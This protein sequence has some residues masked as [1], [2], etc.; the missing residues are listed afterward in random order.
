MPRYAKFYKLSKPGAPNSY[1]FGG[2]N[3]PLT[4][5]SRTLRPN[6]SEGFANADRY[7]IESSAWHFHDLEMQELEHGKNHNPDLR[8]VLGAPLFAKVEK[9]IR[10]IHWPP[11]P[12]LIK[13]HF[14]SLFNPGI[15]LYKQSAKLLLELVI[16]HQIIQKSPSVKDSIKQSVLELK[17]YNANCF[18]YQKIREGASSDEVE[19]AAIYRKKPLITLDEPTFPALALPVM[20]AETQQKLI[21]QFKAALDLSHDDATSV[22]TEVFYPLY[23]MFNYQIGVYRNFQEGQP[24]H[25][26]ALTSPQLLAKYGPI[27]YQHFFGRSLAWME[28]LRG[29]LHKESCYINVHYGQLNGAGNLMRLLSKE[30]FTFTALECPTINSPDV[31]LRLPAP[32]STS[33]GP[34]NKAAAPAIAP[35]AR[36]FLPSLASHAA[37]MPVSASAVAAAAS[38]AAALAERIAACA[39]EEK[40][41]TPAPRRSSRLAK[42]ARIASAV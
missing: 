14:R 18:D 23:D 37:N 4:H 39:L 35:A 3:M 24:I 6:R 27:I 41:D 2:V 16:F 12:M 31:P 5:Y 33:R 15:P 7:F 42:R 11:I 29:P 32:I 8:E 25:D 9:Y 22:I 38:S 40:S 36:T 28:K 19:K 30:G 13:L 10:A 17:F 1:L 20:N 26:P 21:K 34:E